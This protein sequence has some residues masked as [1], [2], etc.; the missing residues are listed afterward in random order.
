MVFEIFGICFGK[1]R[2]IKR[3]ISLTFQIHSHC[4]PKTYFLSVNRPKIT[5][6]LIP[7]L[8]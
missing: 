3:M 2:W 6:K 4:N 8:Y 5:G 7:L 1:E